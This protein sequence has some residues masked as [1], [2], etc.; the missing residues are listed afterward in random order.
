MSN[1]RPPA[2]FA[3]PRVVTNPEHCVFYHTMDLPGV[4]VK[5]GAWD[6]RDDVDNYIGKVN[7][8]GKTVLDVGTGNGF[9]SFEMEK[10]G[11]NMISFDFD[12]ALGRRSHDVVPF[13]DFETRFGASKDAFW[14]Q[15]SF[16]L[17]AMKNGYW[18][19]HRLY[20]SKAR[21]YY[22]NV[23]DTQV[24]MGP[25]DMVFM[26]NINLHLAS[27]VQAMANFAKY[28]RETFVVTEHCAENVDY[29]SEEPL[30]FLVPNADRRDLASWY[31]TW[32]QITPG[33]VK[34]YLKVLGFNR[35]EVTF[36]K[37]GAADPKEKRPHFTVV[38]RR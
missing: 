6:L 37:A 11:A 20:G 18:L 22:G 30:C 35:F 19:A 16:G 7:V 26:G 14:D 24:D 10:R 21:V 8:S 17:D 34:R 12:P 13:H 4:G 36:Y 25:V 32:W 3:T 28:A 15:L 29:R 31:A 27:P 33:F 38:A 1:E 9:L 23:Y 2:V 5:Q